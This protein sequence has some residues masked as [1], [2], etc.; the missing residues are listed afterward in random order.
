MYDVSYMCSWCLK[1][2][3]GGY[4]MVEMGGSGAERVLWVRSAPRV[5]E[6][7]RGWRNRLVVGETHC[8]GAKHVVVVPGA[9]LGGRNGW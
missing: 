5:V 2:E 1:R 9:S 4:G 6:T 8:G 7:R 3:G